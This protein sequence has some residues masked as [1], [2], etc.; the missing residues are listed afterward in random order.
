M[1]VMRDVVANLESGK[2]CNSEL[3]FIQRRLTN[4]CLQ[5][6]TQVLPIKI[7][8][9]VHPIYPGFGPAFHC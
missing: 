7:V 6:D 2:Q 9:L 4:R 5:V 3:G 8:D 1:D